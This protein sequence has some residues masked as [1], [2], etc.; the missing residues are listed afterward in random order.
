MNGRAFQSSYLEFNEF[1]LPPPF[2]CHSELLPKISNSIQN[3]QQWQLKP[4]QICILRPEL[5][6]RLDV[7]GPE[8]TRA[9]AETSSDHKDQQNMG[10][11]DVED[12]T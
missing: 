10:P 12:A 4:F 6:Q 9:T 3:F 1:L 7:S 2:P 11:A 8:K 5:I